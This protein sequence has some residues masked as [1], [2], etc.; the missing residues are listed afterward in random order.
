VGERVFFA[1]AAA[2]IISSAVAV[3]TLRNPFRAAVALIISLLSVALIFL[4]QRAP[5]V[6]MIQVIVYAGAI[7]VLFLFV[8]AYLGDRPPALG[9]D[10]L[11]RY[12]VF[13]WLA[14][15]ALGVEGFIALGNSR[16]PGIRSN[17]VQVSDIGSPHAIGASFLDHFITA[18]EGTSLVLLVAAVGAVLLARRAVLGE[19][20]R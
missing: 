16:L 9:A 14:I 4:L 18:F 2:G 10:P 13:A 11:G 6:A 3:I 17:P 8:I 7:V 15:I 12:Q 1:I 19:R 20:G 5:F